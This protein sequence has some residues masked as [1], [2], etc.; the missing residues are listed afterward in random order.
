MKRF[1][2]PYYQLKNNIKKIW[3]ALALHSTDKKNSKEI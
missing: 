3:H 1:S 2:V